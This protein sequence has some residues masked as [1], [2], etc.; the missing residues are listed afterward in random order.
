[1]L[2]IIKCCMTAIYND[3]TMGQK[4]WV[5]ASIIFASRGVSPALFVHSISDVDE[6]FRM[7]KCTHICVLYWAN[8]K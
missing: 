2:A 1:M 4:D 6:Q 8:N 7:F 5:G 3:V